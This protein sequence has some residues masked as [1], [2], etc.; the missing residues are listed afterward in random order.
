MP[1][2]FFIVEIENA[3]ACI[4]SLQIFS[5]I[6]RR[7]KPNENWAIIINNSAGKSIFIRLVFGDLIF[8][9][10]GTVFWFGQR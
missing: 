8:I 1:N 3:S 5:N 2:D 4:R 10:G 7:M 6:S 9:H